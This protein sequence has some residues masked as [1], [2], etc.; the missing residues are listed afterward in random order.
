MSHQLPPL[1]YAYNALEPFIDEATVRLH[2]DKHHAAY[3]T[4]LNNLLASHPDLQEQS[5]EWLLR[6]LPELTEAIRSAVQNNAGAIDAHT[7]YFEVMTP[8]GAHEPT[9]KLARAIDEAFGS[10]AALQEQLSKAGAG[11]FGSGWAW[12]VVRPDGKLACYSLPGADSP[13]MQGDIPLL[14]L[15]VWEH[16]YYLKYQNRRPEY[17]QAFLQ[18]INWTKVGEK[19]EAV[20]A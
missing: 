13:Y 16:S 12:L 2:H 3:V 8:G 14:T 9:G 15:D 5:L 20:T 19:Y 4:N 6:H 11:R 1:P 17:I 18:L 7:L 10:F